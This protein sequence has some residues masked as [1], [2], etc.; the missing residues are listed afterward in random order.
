MSNWFKEA[1]EDVWEAGVSTVKWSTEVP[2]EVYKNYRRDP[3]L[4]SP[5]D[6]IPPSEGAQG[7]AL[8]KDDTKILNIEGGT[9][10][11][12]STEEVKR[13]PGSGV[14]KEHQKRSPFT[15][16]ILPPA[17]L[18][19]GTHSWDSVT[20][21]KTYNEDIVKQAID[22]GSFSEHEWKDWKQKAKLDSLSKDE[23]IEK[24]RKHIDLHYTILRNDPGRNG[25]FIIQRNLFA[26]DPEE[27]F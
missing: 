7:P 25:R 26:E 14:P 22:S 6:P 2:S 16:R 15:F 4:K 11:K 1:A 18:S 8:S 9:S 12:Y 5:K 17:E 13:L 20:A 23:R 3:P 24:G 27:D 19:N 21:L 10:Y